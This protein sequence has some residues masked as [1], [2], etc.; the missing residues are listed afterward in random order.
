[1]TQ[2][3]Q[4]DPNDPNCEKPVMPTEQILYGDVVYW[5]CVVSALLCMVGPLV[6]M[7]NIDNNV[8]D[9]QFMFGAIW[10]GESIPQIWEK[11]AGGFPGGHFWLTNLTKG[12]GLTQFGLV[13]GGSCA[14]PALLTSAFIY[15][16]K[17][18]MI[19]VGMSVWTSLLIFISITGLISAG[20]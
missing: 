4:Y 9:P 16:K 18:K 17:G 14:L 11:A 2:N 6:A 13:V 12:D 3:T 20:H 10:A 19:W 1:M 15:L 7:F 8:M 5:L